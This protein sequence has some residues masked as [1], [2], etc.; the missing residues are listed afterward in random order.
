[1][2]DAYN[3][4]IVG[5]LCNWC[6]YTGADL[7]GVSR[8]RVSSSLHAIRVMCSGRIDPLYVIMAYLKGADGVMGMGCHPGDCHYLKGNYNARR[9]F[10]MLESIFKTLGLDGKRIGL[11]WV[12]AS[13]G[14]RFAQVTN[15]FTELMK[16]KGPNPFRE[17][18]FI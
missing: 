18:M 13:E 6:A 8:A 1:M 14:K 4:R 7:A 2:S 12:S 9:R 16:T 17:E 11:W 15:E 5:F 3:P 10:V